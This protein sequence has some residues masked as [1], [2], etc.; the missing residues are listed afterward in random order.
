MIDIQSVLPHRYPFLLIDQVVCKEELT[1]AKGIKLVSR[2]DWFMNRNE[3]N[4]KM[5]E[6]LILEAIGQLGAF[7]LPEKE[8]SLGLLSGVR[9]VRFFHSV[10]PGDQLDLEFEIIKLRSQAFKGRGTASV[11]GLKVAEVEE[12]TVSYLRS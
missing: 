1:Y 9:N 6:V 11:K 8:K 12:I 10:H 3:E 2:G 7:V 5:P 4:P